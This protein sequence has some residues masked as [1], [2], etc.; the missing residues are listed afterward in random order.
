MDGSDF[1]VIGILRK[2]ILQHRLLVGSSSV[3]ASILLL[4]HLF[5]GEI[6]LFPRHHL[7]SMI[8]HR[9]RVKRFR[10]KSVVTHVKSQTLHID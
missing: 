7:Y 5:L 1:C 6:N 4:Y 8:K 9:E 3:E 10:L 2:K